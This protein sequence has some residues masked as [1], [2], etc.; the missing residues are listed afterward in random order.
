MQMCDDPTKGQLSG[1][2]CSKSQETNSEVGQDSAAYLCQSGLL[3]SQNQD[4]Y[5]AL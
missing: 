5:L 4:D 2:S 3:P 1:L